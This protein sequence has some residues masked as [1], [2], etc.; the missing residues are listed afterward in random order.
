MVRCGTLRW[1]VWVR[2]RKRYIGVGFLG[3]CYMGVG[4][5]GKWYSALLGGGVSG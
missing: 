2:V 1:C 4:C 3:K 5:L